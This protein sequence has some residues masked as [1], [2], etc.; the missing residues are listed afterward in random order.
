MSGVRA[1]STLANA[2][3]LKEMIG[4]LSSNLGTTEAGKAWCIKALHPSDPLTEVSGVPDMSTGSSIFLNCQQ[5]V[6]LESVGSAAWDADLTVLSDPI[7]FLATDLTDSTG[8]HTT[9]LV[10]NTQFGASHEQAVAGWLSAFERWRCAYMGVSVYLNASDMYNEGAAAAAQFPLRPRVVTTMTSSGVADLGSQVWVSG[11]KLTYFTDTDDPQYENLIK[12]PNAYT[13]EARDGVYLPLKLDSNHATWH[14]ENDFSYTVPN[15][16][17]MSDVSAVNVYPYYTV[18]T[19]RVNTTGA[20]PTVAGGAHLLPCTAAAGRIAFR[21]LNHNAKITVVIRAGFE[22]Q[23]QPSSAYTSFQRLCA[24]HD[25]AAEV[26]YFQ[27]ARQLKDAYPVE[28]NDLGKLWDVI[29]G[30]ARR[31]A[32]I[33]GAV[34]IY[35]PAVKAIGGLIGGAIDRVVARKSPPRGP[36]DALPAATQE[37]VTRAVTQRLSRPTVNQARRMIAKSGRA[38]GGKRKGR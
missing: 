18:D 33:V 30:V 26:A 22:A 14:D 5:Q 36:S 4:S 35:G 29:K 23:A 1:G 19:A 12:M 6:V 20:T 10:H 15:S 28:Y 24:E 37:A 27:I 11:R 38:N 21:G 25:L 8:T 7:A 3:K 13:G 32:P 16:G 9:G 34:P 2:Q 31:V 17:F